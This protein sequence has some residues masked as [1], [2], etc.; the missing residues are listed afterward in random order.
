[1]RRLVEGES[2]ICSKCGEDKLLTD[3]YKRENRPSHMS[4]CKSCLTKQ[5]VAYQ[6]SNPEKSKTK[7]EKWRRANPEKHKLIWTRHREQN[8]DIMRQRCADWRSKNR[9]TANRLSREWAAANPEKCAAFSA[10][11][12]ASTL[13]ATPV[14][15]DLKAIKVEYELAKW[16]SDVMGI[17]Y[18]VDHIIPLQGKNVCGLHVH[19]NCK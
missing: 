19:N 14:W 13:N 10:K 2:K 6:M 15:A 5:S 1:M 3:F 11:R 18:H 7:A 9:E 17:K 8:A 16:C 4:A 12:R